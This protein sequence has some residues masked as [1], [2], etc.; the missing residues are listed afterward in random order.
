MKKFLIKYQSRLA[1]GTILM[2]A[3][4]FYTWIAFKIIVYIG[5]D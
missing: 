1:W 4:S 3:I 5:V 2:M